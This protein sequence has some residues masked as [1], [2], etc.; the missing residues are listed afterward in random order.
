MSFASLLG[1]VILV[2]AL[3]AWLVLLWSAIEPVLWL[4]IRRIV[5]PRGLVR[6]AATLA[7]LCRG[8]FEH[9]LRGGSALAGALAL[10]ARGAHDER[11]ATWLEGQLG[12]PG[13]LGAAGVVAAGLIAASRGQ[14]DAARDL[15]HNAAG[16][17]AERAPAAARVV[18]NEWLVADAAERGDWGT[19][20]RLGVRRDVASAQTRFLAFAAARV[21]RQP[22]IDEPSATDAGLRWLWWRTPDRGRTRPLLL[23]ALATPRVMHSRK[24]TPKPPEPA[25]PPLDPAEFAGDPLAYAQ[26]L[27]AL[28][29]AAEA[30]W[31]ELSPTHLAGL[32]KAWDAAFAGPARTRLAARV[33]VL[34]TVTKADAALAQIRRSVAEDLAQLASRAQIPLSAL[35]EAGGVGAEAGL[36]LRAEL[37]TEVEKQN[38]ALRLRTQQKR[39]LPAVEELRE[40]NSLRRAYERA[41]LLGGL[42][43]RRLM[44]PDIHLHVCNYAVWLWNDRKEYGISGPLFR[45]L[46]TEAE[47]VGDEEA[48]VLQRKNVGVK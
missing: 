33:Q 13:A 11:L 39:K 7:R 1:L 42:E 12:K 17:D 9:D 2:L 20:M 27:H 10:A 38:Q 44:F 25:P 4:V 31:R 37:L 8:G 43:L 40:W 19:V 28:W 45:W 14:R 34:T 16:F 26:A 46:L 41:V 29:T 5:A 6:T 47:A 24:P 21:R 3:A 32:C 36:V 48:I 15:M 22:L 30:A 18:A 23:Q 35:T